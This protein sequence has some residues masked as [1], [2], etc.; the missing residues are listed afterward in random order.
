MLNIEELAYRLLKRDIP[1]VAILPELDVDTIEE[2]PAITFAV[3]GGEQINAD[4]GK[5][6]AWACHLS[7]NVFDVSM[8][9]AFKVASRA[10]DAVWAWDD[11]W[12]GLAIADFGWMDEIS[13]ASIFTRIGGDSD[14]DAHGITQFAGEFDMQAHQA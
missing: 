4:G 12:A 6:S 13:D 1:G 9:A 10:Y 5:P 8:D 3:T 11:P 2:L 14:I 7:L